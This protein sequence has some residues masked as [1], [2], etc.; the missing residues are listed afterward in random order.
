M[1]GAAPGAPLGGR[2]AGRPEAPLAGLR[3][4]VPRGGAWGE[5]VCAWI[6]ARGGLPAMA[7]LLETLPSDVAPE[8]ASAVERWNRGEFDCLAV[9][10]RN[11]VAALAAQGIRPV[12]GATVAAVGP[13]TARALAEIG[14]EVGVLPA[15]DFSADGLADA[16]VRSATGP[17]R[18]LL[19][20]SDLAGDALPESLRAAGHAVERV[21]A[22]RTRELPTDERL[23]AALAAGE[24]DAVLVTSSSA[25]TALAGRYPEIHPRTLLAA[26]GAPTARTLERNGMRADVVAGVQTA[27][28]LLDALGAALAHRPTLATGPDG[29]RTPS[30]PNPSRRSPR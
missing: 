2:S 12:A 23:R 11:G 29:D 22:Y 21:M 16:L 26:I 3:I 17:L 13:A 30:T 14:L 24:F 4:L 25:A 18:V 1:T 15:V 8:L 6:V 27:C 10:S 5:E 20:I 19:P 28:G 9:T 7:P